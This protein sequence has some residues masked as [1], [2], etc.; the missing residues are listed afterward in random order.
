VSEPVYFSNSSNSAEASAACLQRRP[1]PHGIG[2]VE[3]HALQLGQRAVHFQQI[4][5]LLDRRG[6]ELAVDDF[7][8]TG[9][10]PASRAGRA[11]AGA[12][13]ASDGR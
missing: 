11:D 2:L 13:P 7:K 6:I 8:Q 3:G 4:G 12:V 1:E 9:Q 10:R 5:A